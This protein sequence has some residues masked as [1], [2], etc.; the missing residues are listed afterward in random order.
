MTLKVDNSSPSG[1]GRSGDDEIE[2]TPEMIE[3]GTEVLLG[4]DPEY[5]PAERCVSAIYRAM[6]ASRE[7]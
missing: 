3:A 6:I 7:P 2:V 1:A 5:D 4:W